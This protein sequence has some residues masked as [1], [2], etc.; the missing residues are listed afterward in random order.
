MDYPIKVFEIGSGQEYIK[1]EILEVFG[2]PK[3]TSFR[4]GYDIRCNL[5]IKASVYTCCTENYFTATGALYDFYVALQ[6]CYDK[7]NGKAIYSVYYPENNLV[8]EV[9]FDRGQVKIEGTYQDNPA[10]ENVLKFEF[11]SDQSY[12]KQVLSDL[13]RIILT[14]GDKKGINKVR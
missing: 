4:G 1:L 2:F 5:E 13:K 12:F 8:F 7:L 6:D 3:D 14:F 9:E 11:G 10:I